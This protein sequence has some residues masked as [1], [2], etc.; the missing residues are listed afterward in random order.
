MFLSVDAS[1]GIFF[2]DINR[3]LTIQARRT[4]LIRMIV[5]DSELDSGTS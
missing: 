1:T 5:V 4:I 3:K 2:R